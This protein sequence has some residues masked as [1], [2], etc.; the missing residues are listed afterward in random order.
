MPSFV[1]WF[2]DADTHESSLLGKASKHIGNLTQA[3][4]PI[5][6]GFI[7]T[8]K[9]YHTFLKENKLDVKIKK[10]LTTVN[11]EHPESVYQVARHV[12]D[13]ISQASIPENVAQE[14]KDFYKRLNTK[15][16]SLEAHT[17]VKPSHKI[18]KQQISDFESLAKGLKE[19]WT[20]HFEP[21]H[22]WKRHE[23]GHDHLDTGVEV[24]IQLD[25]NAVKTGIMH[26]VNVHNQSKDTL[27]ITVSHPHTSDEYTLTKK[28]LMLIKRK[29]SH[30]GKAPK[31]T[32]QELFKIAKLGKAIEQHLYFPQ[33]I[34]WAIVDDQVY[35]L[36]TKPFSDLPKTKKELKKKLA[37]ARGISITKTIG[38][39]PVTIIQHEHD[40]DKIHEHIVVV[41]TIKKEQLNKLKK[42]K[43]IIAERGDTHSEVSVLIRELG[44][45]TIYGVTNATKKLKNGYVITIH[46]GK[47]EV[48]LGGFH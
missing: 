11:I 7:I 48:Y 28:N 1:V 40:L 47:G 37:A 36:H 42:A 44:I 27:S 26:T 35:V 6:P 45:P 46:A 18:L 19:A 5:A 38:S 32:Y 31:L 8:S 25:L 2:K 4:F 34:Q 24:L 9:A 12:Q 30:Y 29:L 33:Q 17:T 3:G 23:H 16:A 15:K 10:L 20:Q 14:I 43:G 41:S 22:F 39:G 13:L 21:N